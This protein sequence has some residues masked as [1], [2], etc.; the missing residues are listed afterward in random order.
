MPTLTELINV[1]VSPDPTDMG[2]NVTL[3]AVH[4]HILTQH[5]ENLDGLVTIMGIDLAIAERT[6][7][8]LAPQDVGDA[9]TIYAARLAS[10]S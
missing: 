3:P 10:F 2:P 9:R 6:A 4:M 5:I 8:G 1:P 7:I